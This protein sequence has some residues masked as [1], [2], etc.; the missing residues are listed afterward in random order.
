MTKSSAYH[1]L[2][3]GDP[4]SVSPTA[5]FSMRRVQTQFE[6][7]GYAGWIIDTADG[8]FIVSVDRAGNGA[9]DYFTAAELTVREVSQ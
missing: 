7:A 1:A 5:R 4:V 3:I 2:A 8:D 6:Q 9:W